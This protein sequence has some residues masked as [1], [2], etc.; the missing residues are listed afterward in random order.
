MEL[1]DIRKEYALK[2]FD[3]EHTNENPFEQFKIWFEETM[4]SQVLEPTAMHLSTVSPSGKPS[5]RIVL[6][7]GIDNGF[8]FYTN[9]ESRKGKD[10]IHNPFASITFFW[11]ELERQVRI[12]GHIEKVKQELSVSY[13]NSRPFDSRIGAIASPQSQVVENREVLEHRFAEAWQKYEGDE[14]PKPENWGGFRLIPDV[15]E[16]W[17]GRKSRLHDR[18]RY[19]PN[20]ENSWKIERLAP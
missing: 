20:E 15:F 12:E 19:R 11:A 13:F 1:A 6:L 5:G 3:N 10:L 18:L 2:T 7:K 14:P 17:Q 16:F 9:Y 8:L 4:V